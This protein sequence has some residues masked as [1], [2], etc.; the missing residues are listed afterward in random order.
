MWEHYY[1]ILSKVHSM[2]KLVS[3][4]YQLLNRQEYLQTLASPEPVIHTYNRVIVGSLL[5]TINNSAHHRDIVQ[6]NCL[7]LRRLGG[8]TKT[9]ERERERERESRCPNRIK[10]NIIIH[11]KMQVNIHN[12]TH[13]ILSGCA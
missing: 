6:N 1:P 5:T 12:A 4:F 9:R 8:E 3:M 2:R 10:R 11:N 7:F 13:M